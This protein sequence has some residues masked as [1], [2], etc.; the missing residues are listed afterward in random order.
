[1]GHNFF[2]F[3]NQLFC[4]FLCVYIFLVH[5]SMLSSVS[6]IPRSSSNNI[7]LSTHS[8]LC[9][10]YSSPPVLFWPVPSTCYMALNMYT[11]HHFINWWWNMVYVMWISLDVFVFLLLIDVL[12]FIKRLFL[13][14]VVRWNSSDGRHWRGQTGVGCQQWAEDGKGENCSTGS[15]FLF[16]SFNHES[17]EHLLCFSIS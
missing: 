15:I 1:M 3:F 4:V 11:N 17:T 8:W 7:H 12:I 9:H 16:G 6:G 13:S 2:F 10:I 14:P 5:F